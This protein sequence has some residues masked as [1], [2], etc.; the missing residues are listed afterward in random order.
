MPES[1]FMNYQSYYIQPYVNLQGAKYIA[2]AGER[3]E[4]PAGGKKPPGIRS[5][6]GSP[7]D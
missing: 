1:A 2:G 6:G 3:P 7:R 4:A 5:P